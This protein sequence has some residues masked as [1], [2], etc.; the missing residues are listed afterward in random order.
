MDHITPVIF[1]LS[2]GEDPTDAVESLA[3]K[4]K[5]QVD[6]ISMGEGQ[7]VP[8][9]AA[10]KNAWSAGTWVLLQNCELGLDLM[11]DMEQMILKSNP[12]ENFRLMFSANPHPQFPLGLLQMCTKMTNEPPQGLRAGLLRSFNTMIDQDRLERIESSH[13]RRLVNTL[14]FLHSIVHERKKF[15]PLG[16]NIPYEFNTGDLSACLTF[17]EKHLFD[18]EISW[19]TV[20]YMVSMAQYGGKVTDDKDR[21][22][23]RCYASRWL[24]ND[25]MSKDFTFNPGHPIVPFPGNFV[26]K[27][28]DQPDVQAYRD[29]AA[30]MPHID[31]PEIIGLHPNADLTFRLKEVREMLDTLGNTKPKGG[32]G[33]SA[34]SRDKLVSDKAG[35]LLEKLPPDFVP[36]N[37]LQRIK[38]MGGIDIPLNIFLYQEI[39]RVQD[40]ITMVRRT[41][42]DL[43][44]AIKGEVV[45]TQE[46][47]NAIS[48]IFDAR[49]PKNWV[50]TVGGDEFSWYLPTLGLW[51]ASL[52]SRVGQYRKWL[53]KGRPN[54]FWMTGFFNPQGFLTGMKQE[55]TRLHRSDKWALDDVLYHT[56]VTSFESPERAGQ[57]TKGVYVYGLFMEG[58]QWDQ[59]SKSIA[60]SLPK[61]LFDALPVI[62]VS[63]VD[64][65][66]RPKTSNQYSCPVYKYPA[67]TDRYIIFDI[68]LPSGNRPSWH[69]VFRGVAILCS[70]E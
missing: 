25:V 60:E 64:A 44:L 30:T 62:L 65:K 66:R 48:S 68:L 17:L 15:G 22:L 21:L 69:W 43:R 32:G 63:V 39:Q 6:C 8:A 55:V 20:Q 35:S 27:V 45:M 31:S 56:E 52:L 40:V 4:R 24:S 2:V 54:A 12:S 50:E 46:L 49:P 53:D 29:Y 70:I 34:G 59:E 10:I 67:R 1:F 9:I 3:K 33:G 47:V 14:C 61:V 28:L 57:Q 5:T 7:A 11:V 19:P 36:E 18:N 38:A 23:L 41:L 51:Y 42:I 58:A 13:W 37:Y 26:Y 16:W